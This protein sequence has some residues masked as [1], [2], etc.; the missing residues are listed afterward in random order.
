MI[1]SINEYIVSYGVKC[2]EQPSHGS[3]LALIK[4]E[5]HGDWISEVIGAGFT[6]PFTE[7]KLILSSIECYKWWLSSGWTSKI[8]Q[9]T[10]FQ[11]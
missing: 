1:T 4:T 7:E 9:Q 5:W 11:V 10:F 8:N 2:R 3:E 6:L